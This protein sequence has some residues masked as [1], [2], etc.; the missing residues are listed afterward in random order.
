MAR[1]AGMTLSDRWEDWEH[2][3]FTHESTRHVSVW[4]MQSDP[5]DVDRA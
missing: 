5:C 4:K 1:M 3:P 2:T